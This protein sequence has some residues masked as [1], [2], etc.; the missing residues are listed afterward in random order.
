[1]HSIISSSSPV[2]RLQRG[3]IRWT[4]SQHF[5]TRLPWVI[6]PS[7]S[8]SFPSRWVF[9]SYSSVIPAHFSAGLQ[10]KRGDRET[11]GLLISL[12]SSPQPEQAL[13]IK[14]TFLKQNGD[15]FTFSASLK[16]KICQDSKFMQT[17]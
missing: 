3:E 8:L 5:P 10:G 16:E 2:E 13:H 4:C 12:P 7:L 6:S 11:F 9:N 17:D 15:I 1:M 14:H